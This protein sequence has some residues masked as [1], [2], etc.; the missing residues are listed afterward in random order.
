MPIVELRKLR[1]S[2]DTQAYLPKAIG[3]GMGTWIH[4]CLSSKA[5][6]FVLQHADNI[7]EVFALGWGV[8]GKVLTGIQRS[9]DY[10]HINNFKHNGED[11]VRIMAVTVTVAEYFERA[12]HSHLFS[13]S[14]FSLSFTSISTENTSHAFSSVK[15]GCCAKSRNLALLLLNVENQRGES[16]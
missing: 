8:E 11:E 15:G 16:I 13:S 6:Q 9:S 10:V 5:V 2:L 7:Y 1:H 12:A 14:W 3:S 4:I